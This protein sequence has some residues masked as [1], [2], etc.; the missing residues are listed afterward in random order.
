MAAAGVAGAEHDWVQ[1]PHFQEWLDSNCVP[2]GA[3]AEPGTV[4]VWRDADGT[5]T[6]A[7]VT[8]GDG[9]ALEK[10]A[11]TWWTPRVIGT[12]GGVIRASRAPHQR[13]ERHRI[14]RTSTPQA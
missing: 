7:A 4:L 1:R 8:V 2:G 6:H 11:Q 13:L 3:D 10:A 12:V 5:P 14:V 9:W